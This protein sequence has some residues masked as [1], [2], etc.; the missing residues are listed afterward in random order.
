MYFKTHVALLLLGLVSVSVSQYEIYP[1]FNES[2]SFEERVTDLISRL[3]LDEVIAQ[4]SHGGSGQDGTGNDP[5]PGSVRLGIEP[6]SWYNEC[7]R[8]VVWQTATPFP[9]A[10]GLAAT[11]S[12]EAIRS[13]AEATGEEL[14]ALWIDYTSRGLYGSH[15]GLHCCS[16]V[17]NIMRHP[18]WG[19]NQETYGEDP[20]LSGV[21]AAAYVDGLKGRDPKYMRAVAGCKHFAA[22]AGP[23]N[24]PESRFSFNAVVS[25]RDLRVT[26]FPQFKKC[27]EAGTGSIMCSYNMLNGVPN[28]ANPYILNDVLRDDWGFKGF[29]ISDLGAI[30]NM[31]TGESYTSDPVV[32]AAASLQAGLNLEL[33]GGDTDNVMSMLGQAVAAGYV[34]EDEIRGAAF[35]LFMIRMQLGMFDSTINNPYVNY[36]MDIIQS[37]E[38]RDLAVHLA[39]QSYVL[40]TNPNNFLPL[41]QTVYNHVAIVGPMADNALQL[42]GDYTPD[43]NTYYLKTPLQGLSPLG[44]T[45]TSGNGC[46]DNYCTNYTSTNI[47]EAVTGADLVFVCLGTGQAVEAEG[48]D[49]TELTLPGEQGTLLTDAIAAANGAPVV[50]LLFN[51]GPLA[52]DPDVVTQLEAIIE[53][54]LPAQATG[55]ALYQVVTGQ[56]NPAGRLPFTWELSMDQ[57]P[58]MT[59]YTMVNRTYRY[60]YQ[61]SPQFPFG[62]GLSYTTFNYSDLSVTPTT[63]NVSRDVSVTVTNT[64]DRDGDEVIQTYIRWVSPSET[65]PILQ[66]VDFARV[67]I[68]AGDSYT[69]TSNIPLERM[70]VFH[71]EGGFYVEAGDIEFFVGGQQPNQEVNIGSNV[72]ST[73]IT[74]PS[75]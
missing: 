21:M 43:V 53:C 10:L 28:C 48:N 11:W 42:Y 52:L 54:F 33:D 3:T 4:L 12:Y 73:T 7:L 37:Q 58:D 56:V 61:D 51:A 16:P 20:F 35:P 44:T 22:Y 27:V 41:Q 36:S 63:G 60:W 64:G 40:L 17:I 18:L 23:D 19:R 70:A 1:F 6:F 68:A 45:V 62:Y 39:A 31:M 49:R 38:H 15:R 14:R 34:T 24:V 29:V 50:L 5:A 75:E 67:T 25:E 55:D 59:D 47:T 8:G 71:D 30:E 32:M 65:M 57:V 66:L 74:I 46:A 72:L 13:M 2:L 26:F 9:Q 69:Y